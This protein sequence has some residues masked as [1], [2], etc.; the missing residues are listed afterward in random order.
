MSV[1]IIAGGNKMYKNNRSSSWSSGDLNI[2][3]VYFLSNG[4]S[5]SFGRS[6]SEQAINSLFAS[7]DLGFKNY[8]FLTLT[9]R[10]D[11]FSTL[12]DPKSDNKNYLFYPSAGLSYI[13]TETWQKRPSWIS[14]AKVRVS[15]AQ[16]GGGAPD[17]YG[18][19]QTYSAPTSSHL[20]QPLMYISSN[21][22]PNLLKPY[23]STT[24]E[25]G[26]DLKLFNNRFGV[27][28][29]IYDRT[30]TNDIVDAALPVSTSYGSIALNVGK[31]QNRGVEIMLTGTPISSKTGLNWDINLNMAYNK[32]TVF[33]IAEGLES[34]RL[35]MSRTENG[36]VY[37]FEGQPF[38]MVAGHK[39]RQNENGQI[40]YNNANG[41]PLLSDLMPLGRGVPPLNISMTNEFSYKN[42]FLSFLLDSKWGGVMYSC[43]NAYGTYYGLH[44]STVANGVRETGVKV[45]GV[46]QNGET[47]SSTVNA[48]TYFK[49]IGF[50]VTDEFVNKSDFIKLRQ[51]NFGYSVPRPIMAKTPFQSAN[52]SFVAR[53]LL[54]IYTPMENVDPE[55][56]YS[57]AN[58]QGLENFGVPAT[59]SYGLSLAVRF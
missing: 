35:A 52:I 29:T 22:I 42:F 8:L 59:R 46:D 50:S 57:T 17:P 26:I 4:K 23:T 41:I 32:N 51:L 49:G 20:G 43:A 31:V 24:L 28:F 21:T 40:V 7:A 16:V 12:T 6:F 48:E 14:F 15:W 13:I 45:S 9:G 10:Q 19:S 39:M 58:G 25:A 37:H 53:N 11:W 30:T 3:F 44:K 33:R 5:P 47:Y 36:W 18:T 27:D 1:N 34:L 2:P 54:L 38:G 56:N 55:S